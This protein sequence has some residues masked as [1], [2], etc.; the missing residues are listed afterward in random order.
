M[1]PDRVYASSSKGD[2]PPRDNPGIFSSV[3]SID[4]FFR[5]RR[6]SYFRGFLHARSSQSTPVTL[7]QKSSRRAGSSRKNCATATAC[8]LSISSEYCC[9]GP[10]FRDDVDLGAGHGRFVRALLFSPTI[11]RSRPAFE[12]RAVERHLG[13]A[14]G[15]QIVFAKCRH[16][17]FARLLGFENVR[18]VLRRSVF[19]HRSCAAVP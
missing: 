13:F 16:R 5:R 19:V 15:L 7:E 18:L 14:G 9:D 4:L 17:E 6:P 11:P 3:V 8:S 1:R 12:F 2:K 10:P